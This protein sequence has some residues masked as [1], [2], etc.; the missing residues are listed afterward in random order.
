M[1]KRAPVF[2]VTLASLV[3]RLQLRV[4]A[5]FVHMANSRH[6]H[7]TK[8]VKRAL[9]IHK[10]PKIVIM[11]VTASAVR[12]SLAKSLALNQHQVNA[13]HVCLPLSKEL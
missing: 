6:L 9:P 12:G 8:N 1:Q 3:E 7:R 13:L 2:R 11:Q 5:E 10:A 4:S